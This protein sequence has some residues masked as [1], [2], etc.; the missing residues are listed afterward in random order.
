MKLYGLLF[1]FFL[2][3]LGLQLFAQQPK[4]QLTGKIIDSVTRLPIDYATISFYPVNDSKKVDGALADEKGNFTASNI[5]PGSYH[6]A[7]NFIGYS[8]K[9]FNGFEIKSGENILRSEEHTSELQSLMRISYAV[10][11]LK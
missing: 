10:F 2:S 6:I 8:E 4:G 3:L 5:I 1:A 9:V 7:V 11:C